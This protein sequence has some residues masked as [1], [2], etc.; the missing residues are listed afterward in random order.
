MKLYAVCTHYNCLCEA[1]LLSTLNKPLVITVL[2]IIKKKKSL[3]HRHLH[4]D[5]ALWL[6]LSGSNYPYLKQMSMVPIEV[7][8]YIVNP[9][10]IF[11]AMGCKLC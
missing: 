9:D 11:W 8:Q 5:L 6:T 10:T 3:N 1:I 7:R 4:P 2:K